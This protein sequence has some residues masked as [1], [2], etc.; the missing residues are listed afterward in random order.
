MRSSEAD[1]EPYFV[2]VRESSEAIQPEIV[3]IAPFIL[4]QG[5][6]SIKFGMLKLF[7]ID[8]RRASLLGNDVLTS[9][10]AED[11]PGLLLRILQQ[12]NSEGITL[13]NLDCFREDASIRSLLL[14]SEPKQ[15][16]GFRFVAKDAQ[17]L[18]A[19]DFDS[20]FDA[21]LGKMSKKVRYNF[22]RTLSQFEKKTGNIA[23]MKAVTEEEQVPEFLS[24]LDGIFKRSWQASALGY[25]ERCGEGS[26]TQ[27]K[28]LAAGGLLRCYVL[29]NAEKPL[30]FVRGYQY[31]GIYYYEEIGFDKDA[32][33]LEPGTVLN[34]LMLQDLFERDKPRHLDFGFG[35]NDYKRKLGNS[36]TEAIEG[37]LVASTSW[38]RYMIALQTLLQWIYVLLSKAVKSVGLGAV[39]R[40]L[41][42]RR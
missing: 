34:F 11:I 19:I 5:R 40:K 4:K 9:Q 23:R 15:L 2:I 38:V 17:P 36:G 33:N 18:R 37:F 30:A 27:H 22:K 42:K 10:K 8:L 24:E 41:L 6:Y 26:L 25:K 21:Y 12:L 13:I 29:Y 14:S 31:A 28:I 7:S 32:R 16:A 35:E 39:L 20:D 3:A 1:Q